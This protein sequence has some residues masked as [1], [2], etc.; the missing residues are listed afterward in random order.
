MGGVVEVGRCSFIASVHGF[1]M[2]KVGRR[3]NDLEPAFA[4]H[5]VGPR[6][7]GVWRRPWLLGWLLMLATHGSV[8]LR[9]LLL[10]CSLRPEPCS[11]NAP[12]PV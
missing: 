7:I 8:S 2:D 6:V 5:I 11:T 1:G 4:P 10:G 9:W 3:C 12:H